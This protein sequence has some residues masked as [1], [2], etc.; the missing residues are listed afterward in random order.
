MTVYPVVLEYYRVVYSTA[1]QCVYT[2]SGKATLFTPQNST[3]MAALPH[4]R[5]FSMLKSD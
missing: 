5:S 3:G 1:L 2:S 4:N